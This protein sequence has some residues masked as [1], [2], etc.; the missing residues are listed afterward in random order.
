MKSTNVPTYGEKAPAR[1]GWCLKPTW[2]DLAT[3][4]D[5]RG[6]ESYQRNPVT[7]S[8]ALTGGRWVTRGG[9]KVWDGPRPA[10]D[11]Q[12]GNPRPVAGCGTASGY[13][14]HTRRREKPCQACRDAHSEAGRKRYAARV[15]RAA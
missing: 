11:P 15:G 8:H 7:S 9:I 2:A 3:C 12:I 10:D 5:C 13:R 14:R 1:C 4:R 6:V